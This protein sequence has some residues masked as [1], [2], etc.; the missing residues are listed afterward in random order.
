MQQCTTCWVDIHK[1]YTYPQHFQVEWLHSFQ[2]LVYLTT[3][4]P[5][6][7]FHPTIYVSEVCHILD[8]CWTEDCPQKQLLYE[9]YSQTSHAFDQYAIYLPFHIKPASIGGDCSDTFPSPILIC[10]TNSGGIAV[11]KARCCDMLLLYYATREIMIVHNLYWRSDN[12]Y[13]IN[14]RGILAL[15]K[16]G[17][18]IYVWIAMIQHT[19]HGQYRI[20]LTA[21]HVL[22]SL[23]QLA[24]CNSLTQPILLITIHELRRIGL[25][26]YTK[27]RDKIENNERLL[28]SFACSLSSLIHFSHTLS[29][30]LCGDPHASAICV[31]NLSHS[32]SPSLQVIFSKFHMEPF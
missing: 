27:R 12:L 24:Q 32:R 22:L 1:R 14:L 16:Q 7:S 13:I 28:P 29:V 11:F 15:V 21:I 18:V 25:G 5:L 9:Y 31:E 8:L 26:W 30:H 19:W 2:L 17:V 4:H 6:L 10:N 23:S 20:I 3:Q